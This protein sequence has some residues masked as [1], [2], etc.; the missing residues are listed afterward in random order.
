[1]KGKPSWLKDN[2][3]KNSFVHISNRL[4]YYSNIQ[5]FVNLIPLSIACCFIMDTYI[6]GQRVSQKKWSIVK[7][8]KYVSESI[9]K[10]INYPFKDLYVEIHT[11]GYYS[12]FYSSLKEKNWAYG[13]HFEF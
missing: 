9:K 8:G 13:G 11:I 1:M 4:K 12:G 7:W 5:N 3:I 2:S 10:I 6:F